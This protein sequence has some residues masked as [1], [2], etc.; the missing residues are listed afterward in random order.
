MTERMTDLDL[1][2]RSD[3]WCFQALCV[4]HINHHYYLPRWEIEGLFFVLLSS[5]DSDNGHD[6]RGCCF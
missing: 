5:V 6:W 4:S 1:V 3:R 2:G